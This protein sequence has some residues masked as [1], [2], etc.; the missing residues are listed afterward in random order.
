MRRELSALVA[1]LTWLSSAP[2]GAEPL[3]VR[4]AVLKPALTTDPR[5]QTPVDLAALLAEKL[6]NLRLYSA[7]EPTRLPL[8]DLGLAVGCSPQEAACLARVAKELDVEVLLALR[9]I[10]SAD[11]LE[12]EVV[13]HD[14]RG[15]DAPRS[16]RRP[17]AELGEEALLSQTLDDLIFDLYGVRPPALELTQ[18]GTG[19]AGRA[20]VLTPWPWAIGGAATLT[21]GIIAGGLSRSAA[22]TYAGLPTR[23][24]AEV[25]AALDQR[26]VAENRAL[27]A[28]V[29]F[30]VTAALVITGA[31]MGLFPWEEEP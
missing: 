26:S 6:G 29:L 8:Q 1:A 25:D 3:A 15:E 28:N 31:A 22:G 13:L 14:L 19:A 30:G 2:A 17:L 4:A 11:A 12:L 16:V 18:T 24:R 20:L 7:V 23:T 21:A 5:R 27:V 10:G 9:V